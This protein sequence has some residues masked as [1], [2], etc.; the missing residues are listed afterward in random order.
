MS[1]D[2][3]S[4]VVGVLM[5]DGVSVAGGGLLLQGGRVVA[6]AETV[7]RALNLAQGAEPPAAGAE[8]LV[9]F[10]YVAPKKPVK[11]KLVAWAQGAAGGENIAV[12]ELTEPPPTEKKAE[13]AFSTNLPSDEHYDSV[14]DSLE[15]CELVPFF[16]AGVNLCGRPENTEWRLG[17]YLPSGG[18]L[19]AYLASKFNYPWA[20]T[21]DLL[22]V[23]QYIALVR[24][25][26]PLNK[27]LRE[28]FMP[29]YPP[30]P[31]HH[32]F[33]KLPQTLQQR[34]GRASHQLIVT[35]NYDDMM[36]RAFGAAGE[37]FDVVTYMTS[38]SHEQRGKFLHTAPDGEVRLIEKPNEYRLPL[39]E[40]R[41]LTRSVVLK[42]HGAV[43]RTAPD[44]DSYVITEDHYIDYLTRSDISSLVP[45]TLAEKLKSS[46][47][48]FLGYSLRDWNL[49]VILHRI[50][51]EQQQN[52]NYKSWAIQL[53][54][55]KLEQKFWENRDVEIF[56]APLDAYIADLE[57]RVAER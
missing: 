40:N 36:E 6:A 50:W 37:Q 19:S 27:R 22:R 33:A 4:S 56:H 48:L 26:G 44:R 57:R 30:T 43:D 42:I 35:T 18:E 34:T 54:P 20:E 10:S 45:V 51:M 11:A 52:A 8:L 9:E 28:V 23:S 24:G 5:P 55:E 47:F 14:I 49:R 16:G 31:L 53:K 1:E 13:D 2:L 46:N 41:N 32:F 21:R 15:E 38:G 17:E 25:V 29:E 3:K 12:L 39:D 7:A